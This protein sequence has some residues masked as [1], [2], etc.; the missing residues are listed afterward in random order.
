[1]PATE[2]G[3]N[4]GTHLKTKGDVSAEHA[5]Q[6]TKSSVTTVSTVVQ[7]TILHGDITGV[8]PVYQIRE[9]EGGYC[10]GTGSS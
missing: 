9:S 3:P 4:T 5:K 7:V 6:Q 8:Q 10:H 1:M 2:K